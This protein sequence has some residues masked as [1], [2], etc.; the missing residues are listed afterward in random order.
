MPT[1]SNIKNG[2]TPIYEL[3]DIP[4]YEYKHRSKNAQRI[5][6]LIDKR[7]NTHFNTLSKRIVPLPKASKFTSRV[8]KMVQANQ[9]FIYTNDKL[10]ENSFAVLRKSLS[11]K[12]PSRCSKL[13]LPLFKNNIYSNA[14]N[15][16]IYRKPIQK[17]LFPLKLS[18]VNLK[19]NNAISKDMDD[20][21][22]LMRSSFLNYRLRNKL[23]CAV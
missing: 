5:I 8:V 23:S 2:L 13:Y 22:R 18:C 21:F 9:S 16:R 12:R 4:Q 17:I 1:N 20:E 11:T 6:E 10:N 7:K 3:L 19:P 15:F 14:G